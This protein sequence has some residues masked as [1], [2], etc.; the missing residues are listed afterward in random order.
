[1]EIKDF[2]VH[3]KWDKEKLLKY[4]SEEITEH[5]ISNISPYLDT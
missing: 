3:K 1:M 5:I 4:I 2:I